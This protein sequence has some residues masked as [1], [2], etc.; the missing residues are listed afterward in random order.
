MNNCGLVRRGDYASGRYSRWGATR[1]SEY[2]EGYQSPPIVD[3]IF[4]PEATSG[5]VHY[6]SGIITAISSL[7]GTASGST[8]HLVSGVIA[9]VS[10]IT[11]SP[12]RRAGAVGTLTV[13]SAMSG[14]AKKIAYFTSLVSAISGASAGLS[15]RNAI[16]GAVT[17][18]SGASATL[19]HWQAI[20]GII[21]AVSGSFGDVTV[22]LGAIAISGTITATS[23]VFELFRFLNPQTGY[24]PITSGIPDYSAMSS[25]VL[26]ASAISTAS[27]WASGVISGFVYYSPIST[28]VDR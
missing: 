22:I 7:I 8:A 21:S 20:S 27:E 18:T 5:T 15:L 23:K 2:G 25:S 3:Y 9:A 4:C 12:G 14:T 24:S 16:T 1:V 11:G 28:G 19:N 26:G 6:V 13:T 10:A 17:A